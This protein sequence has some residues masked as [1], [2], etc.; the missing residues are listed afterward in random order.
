VTLEEKFSIEALAKFIKL[1]DPK[2]A[3]INWQ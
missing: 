2:K 1:D 3:I